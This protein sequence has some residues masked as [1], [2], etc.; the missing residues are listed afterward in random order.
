M[1][2]GAFG[3]STGLKYLPG[4]FSSTE[5]VISVSSE[6]ARLGGIYTSHLRDEGLGLI[7]SV[8]EAIR[9]ADESDIRV[10]LTHHKAIGQP[11]W[12]ASERTLAMVDSAR[13][14]GLDVMIDQ[15]PYTASFTSMAV[16]I[17]PWALE[18]G[19]VSRFTERCED[20]ALRDSIKAGIVFNIKYDR[21]GNDLNR[22]QIARFN[23]KP[24]LE[25]KTLYDWAIEEGL[26]PT[27]ENGAELIIQGQIK[28]GASCIYHV[29]DEADVVRIMQHPYTMHASDG[30][31]SKI[32]AGHPHP[33]AFGTF[34]R[35]LGHYVREMQVLP[36]EEAIRKM[37]GLP[38][39]CV[40]L[41]DRGLL[42]TGYHADI[43]IFD[44]ATIIDKATFE[45]PNQ[46][47]EG[48]IHVLVNGRSALENGDFLGARHG[49]VLRGPAYV[50]E[51]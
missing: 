45:D 36:L 32:G 13:E 10:V 41:T 6:A 26:E 38:A 49:Q 4:T 48:V 8:Q 44:P 37:T 42:K 28:G 25:G 2:E 21:G 16:L 31:L 43:T 22:I 24:H 7:A 39:M 1:H 40:G 47:P 18:G 30:R 20:P 29:M 34:P 46:F 14:A 23:W 9:I 50:R 27:A 17:P 11:M 12:G 5:E 19:R 51:E 3:I 15:Y 35:V 33:R